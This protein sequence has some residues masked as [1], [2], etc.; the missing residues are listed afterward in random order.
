MTT[1]RNEFQGAINGVPGR[2][3]NVIQWPAGNARHC[4][5]IA[6]QSWV[7]EA[8]DVSAEYGGK[9]QMRVNIRFDDNC[10][11]GHE[12]FAITADVKDLSI[13]NGNRFVAGGCL[14]DDIKRFFPELAPLIKWHLTSTDGPLHYVANT[15]YLAGNRDHNGRLKGEPYRFETVV[16][17][18]SS[19]LP[20]NVKSNFK[21]FL[22][23]LTAETELSLLDISEI[24]H[25]KDS[26]TFKPKYTFNGVP[27]TKWHECPFDNKEE[28]ELWRGIIKTHIAALAHGGHYIKFEKRATA[29]GEG[30]AREFE[31]A[32]E[33]AVWPEATDEQL[34]LEPGQLKALLMQ[35]L[36]ALQAEFK[37]A[38]TGAGFLWSAEEAAR[39][40]SDLLNN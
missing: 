6:N 40:Y 23:D 36:P 32:R 16:T 25:D 28:A 22:Q 5:R 12:S 27:C 11:N 37:A 19:P 9:S 15:V 38:V 8:R 31:A 26:K 10:K 18:G 30:K 20:A 35:R 24:E 34:S 4:G 2:F 14:H 39:S 33:A 13:R 29:W 7:S 1:L 3:C 17:V 21:K